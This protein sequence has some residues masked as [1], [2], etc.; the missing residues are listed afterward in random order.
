MTTDVRKT[1]ENAGQFVLIL[2]CMLS[3]SA[4]M[5]KASADNDDVYIKIEPMPVVVGE[6]AELQL[7]SMTAFP[8]LERKPDIPRLQWSKE[9]PM[10]SR[11]TSIYNARRVTIFKTTYSFTVSAEGVVSLPAMDLKLGHLVKKSD[12]LQFKA[13]K[14]K[15]IDASGNKIPIDDILYSSSMLLTKNKEIYV[16]QEIPF[17]I[18]VYSLQ[19][20]RISYA[21]PQIDAENIVMKDYSAVNPDSS[22]FKKSVL[23][24]VK[25]KG[26]LYAV[27][28]FRGALR[29]ISSGTFSGK[30]IVPCVLKVQASRRRSR[31]GD[32]FDDLFNGG[33]FDSGYRNIQYKL[34][35][36]FDDRQ[37]LSLPPPPKGSHFLGLVGDWDVSFSLSAKKL[38]A[39]EPVTL[40]VS[41]VGEGSLD[42]LTAPEIKIRGFHVYPPE[43]KKEPFFMND[44]GKAEIRYAIIPKRQGN[45]SFDTIFSTFQPATGKYVERSFT[46][47]FKVAENDA[48]STAVV[49]DAGAS[50]DDVPPRKIIPKSSTGILYLK[51]NPSGSIAIPL[52]KNSAFLIVLFFI[53]GPLALVF[54]EL[55]A[56]RRLKLSGDPSLKRKTDAKKRRGE[57]LKCLNKAGGDEAL[58]EIIRNDV[59]PLVN[60]LCGFPPGTSIDELAGKVEDSDLAEC[61]RSGSSSSYM[62]GASPSLSSSDL[63]RK[64]AR[65][66]KT[67]AVLIFAAVPFFS[68]FASEPAAKNSSDPL[69]LYDNF[70]PA[71]ARKIY[72][73]RLDPLYPDPA[74]LYNLGNCDVKAGNLPMALVCFE[75]ARRLAPSDSDILENLNYVRRKLLLPQIGLSRTPIDALA[76][77][78]DSF[79]PDQWMVAL[80]AFWSLCWLIL[81]FRRRLSNRQWGSLLG[82]AVIAFSVCV[83]ANL[84]QKHS[85]YNPNRA[86]VVENDVPIYLLP[87]P[88]AEK[89]EFV[90]RPG[91]EVTIVERRHDWLRIREQGAEGWVRADAV[92]R[93]WPYDN[94]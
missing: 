66:L 72:E 42:S 9:P 85:T 65:A 26:Q 80:A 18:R 55:L 78:R 62:P 5:P 15:L 56:Y 76:N 21:W 2:F 77:F 41:I 25:L 6:S 48:P 4:W 68:S 29:P 39:G 19:G 30:V 64:L 67:L 10:R 38:K 37:V 91:E 46:K 71:K 50:G 75:R 49:D 14:R 54:S 36:K 16:G 70:E 22:Y 8:A 51:K 63:K 32:P 88:V 33:L 60:D 92:E 69:A 1:A 86:I 53:L 79:R 57:V 93:L 73:K 24:T 31:S 84:S 40:K 11:Q 3:L 87:S 28:I 47:A 58:H 20:L 23:R 7:V 17:E 27:R 94:N 61:L 59:A 12:P 34:V 90:L 45:I 74:W 82:I 44:R 35:S 89:A 83:A 43:V 13:I 81:A 52:W